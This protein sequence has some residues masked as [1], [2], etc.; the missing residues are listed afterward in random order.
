[1]DQ[2]NQNNQNDQNPFLHLNP[3]ENFGPGHALHDFGLALQALHRHNIA[4][5]LP[6]DRGN[7][8]VRQQLARI[9]DYLPQEARERR[10]QREQRAQ[11]PE[12]GQ[13]RIERVPSPVF[14][15]PQGPQ[16]A[17]GQQAAAPVLPPQPAQF[18][19]G[20]NQGQI[21]Q[22]QGIPN[23][24]DPMNFANF[25]PLPP[26]PPPVAAPLPMPQGQG[27]PGQGGNQNRMANRMAGPPPPGFQFENPLALFGPGFENFLRDGFPGRQLPQEPEAQAPDVAPVDEQIIEDVQIDENQEFG[28]DEQLDE[29]A[30]EAEQVDFAQVEM[31][32]EQQ[33]ANLQQLADLGQ[34]GR[35]PD[36]Q[37]MEQEPQAVAPNPDSP[38]VADDM[39]YDEGHED[40][41]D[42]FELLEEE[43]VRP[44]PQRDLGPI[45]YTPPSFEGEALGDIFGL[46]EEVPKASTPPPALE[47][48]DPYAKPANNIPIYKQHAALSLEA[49]EAQKKRDPNYD[50]FEFRDDDDD[51]MAAPRRASLESK[52]SPKKIEQLKHIYVSKTGFEFM[53]QTAA[54]NKMTKLVTLADQIQDQ[55]DFEMTSRFIKPTQIRSSE[56]AKNQRVA[57]KE[58]PL[59]PK[60]VIKTMEVSQ[61]K[62]SR[63]QK[64]NS[65]DDDD[66]QEKSYSI[67]QVD[68][69]YMP[70]Y[71]FTDPSYNEVDKTRMMA[72]GPAEGAVKGDYLVNRS[73]VLLEN[74][75]IYKVDGAD[76]LQKLV[77]YAR[78]GTNRIFYQNITQYSGWGQEVAHKYFRISVNV[79][80]KFKLD[81]TVEPV[82]PLSELFCAS[83]IESF[84]HPGIFKDPDPDVK[85]II[86]GVTDDR[87]IALNT[88]LQACLS[89]VFSKSHIQKLREKKNWDFSEALTEIELHNQECEAMILN[90]IPIKM[91]FKKCIGTYT[92]LVITETSFHNRTA[93]QVCQ[94]QI[95]TRILQFFDD[96]FYDLNLQV[97]SKPD[98]ANP[99]VVNIFAC[100]T[101]SNALES[102]HKMHHLKLHLL[103]T[104]QLKLEEIGTRQ[105]ELG[106]DALVR[107]AEADKGW[108][109]S[110]IQG[111]CSLWDQVKNDFE[112]I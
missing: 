45:Q 64:R 11:Q 18:G 9:D 80:K 82:I 78:Q 95:S 90:R 8:F 76:I 15:I 46:D 103:R 29:E 112:N 42:M 107:E 32:A 72:F 26:L 56:C 105:I 110:V 91:E 10:E 47:Q 31:E 85:E 108:M 22:F 24:I 92:R 2:N 28:D 96:S 57:T 106:A 33:I 104:C 44:P 3:F 48:N 13:I 36:P 60:F 1:M 30:E 81:V 34:I 79:I 58:E 40:V 69:S 66:S 19:Q 37:P 86:E 70:S 49:R 100:A 4:N 53:G 39:E 65:K 102:L 12:F 6:I 63:S 17:P 93:C 74:C 97:D 51:E 83:S 7:E 73:D 59:L 38:E 55:R 68:R 111:Y 89:Q 54:P 67:V 43:E 98:E 16:A 35:G 27:A 61:R 25:L 75:P 101:C 41:N 20:G 88:L 99:L 109:E 21:G 14:Y 62:T 77:P 84:R 52:K 87:R 5:G 23:M 71:I 50:P 94:N